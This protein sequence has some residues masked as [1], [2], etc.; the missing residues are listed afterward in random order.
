[1]LVIA[2]HFSFVVK[3]MTTT[4]KA[5]YIIYIYCN[6]KPIKVKLDT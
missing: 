6:L 2:E 4:T 1:M 3:E 5:A